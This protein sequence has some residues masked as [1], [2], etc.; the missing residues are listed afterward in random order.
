MSV[1]Q[2]EVQSHHFVLSGYDHPLFQKLIKFCEPLIQ[3]ETNVDPRKG[4]ET[5][6]TK[7]YAASVP[8]H[9]SMRFHINILSK[10]MEFVKQIGLKPDEYVTVVKPAYEPARMKCKLKEH[11]KPRDY[12]VPIV[13]FVVD[14]LE[15]T[16][17]IGIQ[18][19]RGKSTSNDTWVR[20]PGGWK[21]MGDLRVGDY[22]IGRNGKPTRVKGAYPQGRLQ[23]YEVV[24]A[25]GRKVEVCKE[26]LWGVYDS[27]D[28]YHVLSTGQLLENHTQFC[29][30]LPEPIGRPEDRFQGKGWSK[31]TPDYKFT[32]HLLGWVYSESKSRCTNGL[33][34]CEIADPE[35]GV[36]YVDMARSIGRIAGYENGVFWYW[37]SGKGPKHLGIRSIT[38]TRVDEATCI[39]VEAEDHLFVVQDYIV[40]HN[41]LTALIAAAKLGLRI[42]VVL[43]AMYA[44][45]WY[46][47]IQD[48]FKC[49]TKDIM[50]VR[51]LKNLR[52]VIQMARN[53][54]YT[55][56]FII[57]SSTTMQLLIKEYETNPE[58][59]CEM[60]C[61]P[62]EL[63]ELLSVGT[64]IV[65]ECHRNI[66]LNIKMDLYTHLPKGVNLSATLENRDPFIN[67]MYGMIYPKK[68]RYDGLEYDRYVDVYALEYTMRRAHKAKYKG[69][70]GYYNHTRLEQWL[71]KNPKELDNYCEMIYQIVKDCYVVD[72][73]EG[74]RCLIFAAFV[75]FCTYLTK[76]LQRKIPELKVGRYVSEDDYVTLLA[77]DISVSTILSAGTGV[78]IPG[79]REVIMTTS[80]DSMQANEQAKGRLRRL[81]DFPDVTPRFWYVYCTQIPKQ[82]DY[83]RNKEKQFRGTC[84][85][86]KQIQTDYV[87]ETE[88]PG[89]YIAEP[90]LLEGNCFL[91]DDV[92]YFDQHVQWIPYDEA[93]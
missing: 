68:D 89:D 50:F 91:Q 29:V 57:M 74:Q 34:E 59:C 14:P 63:F 65:D 17:V 25:D 22:V 54:E 52:S 21:R 88:V 80:I 31:N 26:H 75:E 7:V 77:N 83:H 78:D 16:R 48:A 8:D 28:E 35:D 70:K 62:A 10:F 76:Y 90:F 4:T 24:F 87:V 84:R 43:P 46:S 58:L 6:V 86:F 23:L 92:G 51:G 20:I 81:K 71:L 41:T 61:H 66:H 42:A 67:R 1:L 11:I 39:A 27:D 44:E 18:A 85:Y 93:A 19:G 30:P 47:D 3:V 55:Q 15:K 40:T 33:V 69:F 56:D 72:R 9:T 53:G 2:I 79:L 36:K 38:P 5:S 60:Y 49:T 82:V 13:D 32:E 45:Q 73:L 12:Q 37:E 64:R